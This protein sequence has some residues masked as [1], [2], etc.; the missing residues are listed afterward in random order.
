VAKAVELL[1]QAM[2]RQKTTLGPDDPLTLDT[3]DRLALAYRHAGDYTRAEATFLE[4]LAIKKRTLAGD[5]PS[6]THTMAGLAGNHLKQKRYTEAESLFRECLAIREKKESG[7]W[8]YFATHRGLGESLLG[9]KKY[10]EAEKHLVQGYE[11]LKE[12]EAT[13]PRLDRSSVTEALEQI[14]ELYEAWGKPD[15]AT[16]WRMELQN[17]KLSD[18]RRASPNANRQSDDK[19]QKNDP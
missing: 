1:E 15:E 12:R 13:I 9:Q 18:S 6:L 19:E 7:K 2:S 4:A 11:G 5:D 3:I 17:R 10:A 14:V 16:K 8:Q